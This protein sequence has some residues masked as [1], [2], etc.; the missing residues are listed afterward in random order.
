ML[1]ITKTIKIN[2][3]IRI[4]ARYK[5]KTIKKAE[6]NS[7]RA[8]LEKKHNSKINFEYHENKPL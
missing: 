1:T 8:E 7:Y 5:E 4:L 3:N 6:L 2:G